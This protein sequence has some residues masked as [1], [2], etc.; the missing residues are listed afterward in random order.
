MNFGD[1]RFSKKMKTMLIMTSLVSCFL[2]KAQE[3]QSTNPITMREAFDFLE[4]AV[5]ENRQ[6]SQRQKVAMRT[7]LFDRRSRQSFSNSF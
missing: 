4:H 5:I 3:K 7:T 6:S 2:C 1:N